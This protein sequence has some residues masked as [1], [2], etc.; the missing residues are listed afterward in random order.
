LNLAIMLNLSA[1][2]IIWQV[3]LVWCGNYLWLNQTIRC[4]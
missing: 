2:L 1:D 3:G 4:N